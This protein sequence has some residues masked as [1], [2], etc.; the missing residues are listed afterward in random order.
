MLLITFLIWSVLC[1]V[2]MITFRPFLIIL[3]RWE[4]FSNTEHRSS[5]TSLQ[6]PIALW[7]LPE[8][9]QI[10]LDYAHRLIEVFTAAAQSNELVKVRG[11]SS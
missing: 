5:N 7:W 11:Y 8:A 1:H 2:W 6:P 3:H 9:C 10:A 4:R